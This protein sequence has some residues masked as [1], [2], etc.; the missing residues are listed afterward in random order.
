VI[1]FLIDENLSPRLVDVAQRFGFV[2][3]HV[4]HRG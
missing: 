1:Q 3:Y 4:V 2:A